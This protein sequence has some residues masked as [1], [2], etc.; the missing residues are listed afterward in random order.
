MIKHDKR[1]ENVWVFNS[2]VEKISKK[3]SGKHENNFVGNE[4]QI[5]NEI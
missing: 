1:H 4:T 2:K 5:W 3:I